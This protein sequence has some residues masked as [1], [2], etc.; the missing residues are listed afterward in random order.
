VS[1]DRAGVAGDS[2]SDLPMH[3]LRDAVTPSWP[4]TVPSRKL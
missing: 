2:T 4:L 1:G 3:C